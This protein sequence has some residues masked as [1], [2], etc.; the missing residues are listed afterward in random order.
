MFNN[1]G[2]SSRILASGSRFTS[3]A[4]E[5]DSSK[6]SDS[7]SSKTAE[8]VDTS[9]LESKLLEKDKLIEEKDNLLKEIQVCIR[10]SISVVLLLELVRYLSM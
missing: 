4:T 7:S 9:I 2:R 1:L 8:G 10:F 3:A 6:N 5:N